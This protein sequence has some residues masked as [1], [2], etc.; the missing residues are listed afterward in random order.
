MAVQEG[1]GRDAVLPQTRSHSR[2][3]EGRIKFVRGDRATDSDRALGPILEDRS[4]ESRLKI[5]F[6]KQTGGASNSPSGPE[7]DGAVGSSGMG[8]G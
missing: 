6:E 5:K 2:V 3:H 7:R 1:F 4:G 8:P